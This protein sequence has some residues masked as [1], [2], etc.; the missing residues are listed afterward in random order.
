MMRTVVEKSAGVREMELYLEVVFEVDV[1][2][3]PSLIG[4][5]PSTLGFLGQIMVAFFHRA[6]EISASLV[7]SDSTR[8]NLSSFL[9]LQVDN[10]NA[11]HYQRSNFPQLTS[12]STQ[13]KATFPTSSSNL[14]SILRFHLVNTS[15]FADPP[16]HSQP[17]LFQIF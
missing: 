11:Y 14:S 9:H 1:L 2:G 10:V 12:G 4:M 6:Q 16:Q 3:L 7:C 8:I 15:L 17:P 5:H 13:A